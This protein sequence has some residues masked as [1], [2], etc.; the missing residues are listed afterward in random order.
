MLSACLYFYA[1]IPSANQP[2]L[3]IFG[4][5]L[6]DKLLCNCDWSIWQLTVS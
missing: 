5:L 2:M 3:H 4:I 1:I 6:V